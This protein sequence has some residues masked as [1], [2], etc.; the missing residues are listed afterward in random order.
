MKK[1]KCTSYRLV[2]GVECSSPAK[3][4]VK[5]NESHVGFVCGTHARQ[6]TS[7]AL[8]LLVKEKK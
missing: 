1:Q 7:K 6:Y 8:F 5:F 4:E 2:D 3:Y